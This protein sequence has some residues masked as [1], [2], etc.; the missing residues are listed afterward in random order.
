MDDDGVVS[1]EREVLFLQRALHIIHR[2]L[3]AVAE[4]VDALIASDIDQH[5]ARDKGGNVLD[6]EFGEAR[7]RRDL[8]G[9]EAVVVTVAVALMGATYNKSTTAER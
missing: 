7:A 5:A 9:L 8:I 4:H 1:L 6:T 3:V 2:D